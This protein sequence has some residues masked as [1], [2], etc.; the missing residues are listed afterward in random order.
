MV[1][2]LHRTCC[3]RDAGDLIFPRDELLWVEERGLH[4]DGERE[5][6]T[7]MVLGDERR[8]RNGGEAEE[9]MA[10]EDGRAVASLP[11]AMPT[12][13]STSWPD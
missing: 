2:A 7:T 12:E 6:H 1:E 3:G 10:E 9:V 5:E 11:P 13:T 4:A 8:G